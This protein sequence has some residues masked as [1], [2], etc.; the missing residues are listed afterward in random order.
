MTCCGSCRMRNCLPR[1]EQWRRPVRIIRAMVLL[2]CARLLIACVPFDH[3]RNRL[4][5]AEQES[6]GTPVEARRLA[7]DVE[8][9]AKRL[10]FETKCLPRAMTLSWLL[11]R[12]RVD[13]AFVIAV[14]PSDRRTSS[15]HLHAW[16]EV[17]GAIILGDLPGPWNEI[18][19]LR[20]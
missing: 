17:G 11:R 15:D 1:I 8:W 20:G 10:P 4:G 14:R 19:R 12:N 16:V 7:A 5:W 9:A 3:W 6:G 18:A 2:S 13:H